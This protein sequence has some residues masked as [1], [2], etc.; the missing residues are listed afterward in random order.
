MPEAHE[1]GNEP[2]G[3]F[4]GI[5]AQEFAVERTVRLVCERN[6]VSV[7][8]LGERLARLFDMQQTSRL[9]GEQRMLRATLARPG[10][11][12]G[13]PAQLVSQLLART[14]VDRMVHL[15]VKLLR[16]VGDPAHQLGNQAD[17]TGCRFADPD[18]IAGH[19]YMDVVAP[20]LRR[21]SQQGARQ[22]GGHGMSVQLLE[23]RCEARVAVV[24]Q[25]LRL[26]NTIAQMSGSTKR[27]SNLA[28]R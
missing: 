24:P 13:D 26:L 25:H 15:Q 7:Q 2:V 1:F 22:S 17:T 21:H 28:W 10:N 14:V 9:G 11:Q 27:L 3:I 20:H 23:P 6:G 16:L 12:R 19:I 8:E 18:R 4:G 5:S